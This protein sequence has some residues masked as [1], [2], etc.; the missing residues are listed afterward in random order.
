[1]N[2]GDIVL[3]MR[4]IYLAVGLSSFIRIIGLA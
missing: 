4:A 3:E 2:M 1:M